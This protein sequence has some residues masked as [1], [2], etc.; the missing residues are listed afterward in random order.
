MTTP[1]YRR[2]LRLVA[3]APNDDPAAPRRRLG[4]ALGLALVVLVLW[5]AGCS[6]TCPPAPVITTPTEVDMPVSEQGVPLELPSRTERPDCRGLTPG[7]KVVCLGAYLDVLEL[8]RARLRNEIANHNDALE[9]AHP[10]PA[11]SP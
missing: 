7:E 9:H 5:L 3:S 10:T 6:T 1:T 4:I 11:P 2:W 8:E